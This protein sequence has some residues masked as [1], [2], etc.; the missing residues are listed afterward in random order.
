MYFR[1]NLRYPRL[2]IGKIF[3]R[4]VCLP[5]AGRRGR[6]G[7]ARVRNGLH[8]VTVPS[9]RPGVVT[10]ALLAKRSIAN[11][12]DRPNAGGRGRRTRKKASNSAGPAL[13]KLYNG[14]CVCSFE[15]APLKK[16][17]G[18]LLLCKTSGRR[19]SC[20]SDSR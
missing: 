9:S 8:Q 19:A 16:L 12:L 17:C 11:G 14:K 13:P 15:K 18:R 6:L 10:A 3:C 5:T 1:T 4:V 7:S 20:S 2:F